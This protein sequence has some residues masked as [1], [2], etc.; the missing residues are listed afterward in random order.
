MPMII[1]AKCS[2]ILTTRV[3]FVSRSGKIFQMKYQK[4]TIIAMVSSREDQS[5]PFS[6]WYTSTNWYR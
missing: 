5:N 4:M 3:E 1:P 6:A 2:D